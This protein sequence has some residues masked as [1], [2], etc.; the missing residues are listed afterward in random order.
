MRWKIG[1]EGGNH[2]WKWAEDP[3]FPFSFHFLK[4]LKFV[5]GL[6]K[7]IILT[8]KKHISRREKIGKSDLTPLKNIPL[9]PL[10]KSLYAQ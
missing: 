8:G 4:P 5:C 10:P 3:F 6:R 1:M 7:W 2:V 9:T